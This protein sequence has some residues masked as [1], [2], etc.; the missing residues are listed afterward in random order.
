MAIVNN[1]TASNRRRDRLSN[2]RN[3]FTAG[4]NVIVLT[5]ALILFATMTDAIVEYRVLCAVALG[6]GACASAFYMFT[7]R[8]VPL[9]EDCDKYDKLY[10]GALYKGRDQ[11]ADE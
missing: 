11:T 5:I 4:A 9:T 10:K 1:I 7:I 8:E 6:I 2:S 3:G